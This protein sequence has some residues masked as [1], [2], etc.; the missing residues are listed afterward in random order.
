ML[1]AKFTELDTINKKIESKEIE[2][3]A[4]KS[5]FSREFSKIN[6]KKNVY[7]EHLSD[8]DEQLLQYE[9]MNKLYEQ[10][11]QK[12]TE[13][14][15]QHKRSIENL[16]SQI[17]GFKNTCS[18]LNKELINKELLLKHENEM[19]A[20]IYLNDMRLKNTRDI[21]QKQL[22]DIQNLEVAIK[23]LDFQIVSIDS[24]V[25]TL[26]EE[27]QGYIKG[28]AFKEASRVSNELTVLKKTREENLSNIAG[29]KEKIEGLRLE[30]ENVKID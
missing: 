3:D 23:K 14:L 20:K 19:T 15:V 16:T 24:K 4:I 21:I 26:E 1:D 22:Q 27:K 17:I 28:K 9:S 7:E 30:I 18:E 13:K 8:Y 25:P 11:E 10:D 2:I 5:N 6:N 12:Y 29:Y